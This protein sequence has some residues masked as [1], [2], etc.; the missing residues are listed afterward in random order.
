M[1]IQAVGLSHHYRGAEASALLELSHT[2]EE[3]T[4]TVVS[5]PSGSGKS[6][7][8]Y[9]LA[10]MLTPSLG[11]IRWGDQDVQALEDTERSELRAKHVGFVFQDAVLDLSSSALDNVTEAG[12]LAGMTRVESET[13]ASELLEKFGIGAKAR[14]RPGEVS[15]GQA[16]RIALCRALVKSPSIIFADEPTG[17]LD[18]DSADVVWRALEDAATEEGATVIVATH[19][20]QRTKRMPNQLRLVS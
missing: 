8:L 10:L 5:G 13:K 20:K 7:L 14:F 19:D 4:L 17:N 2:F 1:Q 16:Q 15:G 6:T 12:W 18:S 9:L 11:S 3:G